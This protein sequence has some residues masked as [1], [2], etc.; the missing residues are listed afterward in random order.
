MIIPFLVQG[1]TDYPPVLSFVSIERSRCRG[2]PIVTGPNRSGS[3]KLCLYSKF[4]SQVQRI[5]VSHSGNVVNDAPFGFIA[6]T[7]IL[8]RQF[9][10]MVNEVLVQASHDI[11][12][13]PGDGIIRQYVV[14]P[15]EHELAQLVGRPSNI[16]THRNH[17]TPGYRHLS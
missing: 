9:F 7:Y 15:F 4:K 2:Q 13:I 3:Q 10:L 11:S 16:G 5:S 6:V 17:R 1:K 12:C 14:Y 8:R